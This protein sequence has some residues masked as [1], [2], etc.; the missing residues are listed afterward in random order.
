[1]SRVMN[2]CIWQIFKNPAKGLE[3]DEGDDLQ[4]V[5]S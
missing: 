3:I 5:R 1:M 2:C 4:G